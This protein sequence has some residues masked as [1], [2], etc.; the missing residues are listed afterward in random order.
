MQVVKRRRKKVSDVS[1]GRNEMPV[2]M[3]KAVFEIWYTQDIADLGAG[4]T[5]EILP[6]AHPK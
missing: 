1:S 3:R 6:P 5:K 4:K 2:S